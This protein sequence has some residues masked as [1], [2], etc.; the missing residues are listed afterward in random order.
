VGALLFD[1]YPIRY[2]DS[3]LAPRRRRLFTATTATTAASAAAATAGT[4]PSP[5]SEAGLDPSDLTG[6]A[7]PAAL[8][9]S[10][11]DVS[12]DGKTVY[13]RW[14]EYAKPPE[15]RGDLIAIDVATGKRRFLTHGDAWYDALAVSPNGR[16]LAATRATFGSPDEASATTLWLVDLTTG[17]GR[18]LTPKL[19]LCRN[20]RSGRPTPRR[21]SSLPIATAAWRPCEST[22][23]TAPLLRW[24]QTARYR[25]CAPHRTVRPSTPCA[26]TSRTPPESSASMPTLPINP[27][28]NWPTESPKAASRL[29]HRWRG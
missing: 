29:A 19:D 13:T 21:S 11:I 20:R 10:A 16:Y 7:G 9:E 2:W 17:E 24:S 27:P 8:V 4:A 5:D 1:E 23:P 14:V 25:T 28:S 12:P 22:W 3:W 26:P 6:D 18:D 15:I